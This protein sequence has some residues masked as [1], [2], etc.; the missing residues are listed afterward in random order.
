MPRKM[1]S[2]GDFVKS[3]NDIHGEG[4]YDYSKSVYT[5]GKNKLL[6]VCRACDC[7]FWQT[8]NNHLKKKGC[9]R[10]GIASRVAKRRWNTA[11]FILE[12]IKVRGETDYD[13][14]LVSYGENDRCKVE[15]ICNTC[16]KS[17]L[18]SPNNHLYGKGCPYCKLDKLGDSRRYT[19]AEFVEKSVIVHGDGRYDYGNSVYIDIKTKISIKCN[20]CGY[21][22]DQ[23]PDH[24]INRAQGCPKCSESRGE[25]IVSMVLDSL[26]VEYQFQ[27]RFDT[28]RNKRSLPFD[29]YLPNHDVCI[30]YHGIQHYEPVASWG[31]EKALKS[32]QRRD[33]IKAKF[34][35]DNGIHLEVIPYWLDEAQVRAIVA[36]LAHMQLSLF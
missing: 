6:I 18:Q 17:F 16:K 36:R 8:P 29:F 5:G 35:K 24:H 11:S 9:P 22:F 2:H 4:R 30:E 12:A 21:I 32:C 13:Y 14:S 26:A 33:K 7:E 25:R 34:C 31:G 19:L 3:A 23:S 20:S 28:C 27:K 15:I 1:K 10:C